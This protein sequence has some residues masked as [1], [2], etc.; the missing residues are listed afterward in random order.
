MMMFAL[1]VTPGVSAK[2][3]DVVTYRAGFLDVDVDD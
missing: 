2:L 1:F 3:R